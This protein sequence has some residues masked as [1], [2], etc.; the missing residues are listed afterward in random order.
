MIIYIYIYEYSK[1]EF[2]MTLYLTKIFCF[3][4]YG[5]LLIY[6]GLHNSLFFLLNI[7][8]YLELSTD[9]RCTFISKT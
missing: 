9:I 5:D 6:G 8:L 2:L 4:I 3:I 7:V 1:I